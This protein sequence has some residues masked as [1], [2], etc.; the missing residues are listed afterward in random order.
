MHNARVKGEPMAPSLRR[1]LIASGL[2][3]AVT[4]AAAPPPPADT[5][6]PA[7]VAA[8]RAYIKK[9]WTTLTRSTRDLAKAAPDPKFPRAPGQPWPV[10]LPVEEDRARVQAELKATMT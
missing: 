4:A 5:L 2:S 1:A 6:S 9:G 10:Y 8:V 3:I 7:R